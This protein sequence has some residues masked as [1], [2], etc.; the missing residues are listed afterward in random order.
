M[1]DDSAG[2]ANSELGDGDD[3]DEVVPLPVACLRDHCGPCGA[4]SLLCEDGTVRDAGD[5]D[6]KTAAGNCPP[7]DKLL[8]CDTLICCLLLHFRK[9]I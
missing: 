3:D 4:A 8:D 7:M 9:K 1:A 5:G 6:G 2:A